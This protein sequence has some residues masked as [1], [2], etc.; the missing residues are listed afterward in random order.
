MRSASACIR[1]EDDA[2]IVQGPVGVQGR[3]DPPADKSLAHR[4]LILAALAAGPSTLGGFSAADDVERTLSALMQLGVRAQRRS[5]EVHIQGVGMHGLQAAGTALDCGNSATT[6]RLLCGAL[7][8]RPFASHLI[9]DGSL[10][11]R[12]MRRVAAPLRAMGALI[13]CTGREERPPL[14]LRAGLG[15]RGMTHVIAVDSAQVRSALLLAGLRAQGT[16]RIQPAGASRD[17]TERMLRALGVRID[18]EA[19]GLAL[20]PPAH[21][22]AGFEFDCPGDPS[23]VAF[24]VA[25]AMA[26]GSGALRVEHVDLNPGRLRYLQL[27]QRA[28]AETT[29]QSERSDLGEPV[30]SIEVAG[31]LTADIELC[32][33]DSVQCIDEIPALVAA[34]AVSG[35]GITVRDAAELRVKETDRI[36]S[37]VQ[38]LRAFGAQADATADGLQLA[39]GASLRPAQV[40]SHGDHRIA[41]AAAIL[42]VAARGTSRIEGTRCVRTSYPEFARD[43]ARLARN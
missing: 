4:A 3:L 14:H 13:E 20:E 31:S 23:A 9:G 41:M 8:A 18:A 19:N 36:A 39:P 7:A 29:I 6:M 21:D 35:V 38:L 10:S 22:W 16:T 12:P 25:W 11:R 40:T 42:A 5:G 32:G 15:L 26:P 27:L 24:F 28:G 34:A 43:F 30:G 17:H 2:W 33:A 37:L 1:V